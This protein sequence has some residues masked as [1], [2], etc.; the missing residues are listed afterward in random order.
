MKAL[1]WSST[2]KAILGSNLGT[3]ALKTE[4]FSKQIGRF[5]KTRK[6]TY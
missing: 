3:L 4:D 2:G 1:A 5:S 6:W